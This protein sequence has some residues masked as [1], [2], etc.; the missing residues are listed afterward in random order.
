V[1]DL[2]V[3]R[4]TASHNTYLLI[5]A[6]IGLV[7][8]SLY[9]FPFLWWW[10]ASRKVWRRMPTSGL[11]NELMLAILWL[12]LLDHVAVSSFTD[13]FQSNL[14]GRTVWWMALG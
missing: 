12:Y 13:M 5:T 14:F 2:A 7:G 10:L 8:F 9:M 11:Y 1:L 4:P 3:N 6:E